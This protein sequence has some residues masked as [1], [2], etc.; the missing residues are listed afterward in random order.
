LNA[1]GERGLFAIDPR[2][3]PALHLI[4][5][6]IPVLIADGILEDPTA[7]R[8]HALALEYRTPDYYYPG[9]IAR[10]DGEDPSLQ[11]FLQAV[12]A[13]VNREYLAR[14]PPISGGGRQI[15][16]FAR[17]HADFAITDVHPGE[18][19]ATQRI[20]HTD[21]VP[22]FGLVYLNEVDRGGTM[23]FRQAEAGEREEQ[24]Q[25]YFEAGDSGFDLIGKIEGR[26]NRLTIYPG[27]VPHSGEIAG[28]WISTDARFK[29][30]RLTLRLA[31]FP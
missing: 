16:A 30:P 24:R 14:I 4:G 25:G 26:F 27:F 12:L 5:G 1:D 9:R 6:Q 3:R 18:L 21:P 17:I 13:L 15:T 22:I 7:L 2:A 31:F 10:A 29:S 11:A 28:D 8:R 20:P 19:Q 23:F